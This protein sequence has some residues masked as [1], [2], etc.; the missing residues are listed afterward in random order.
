MLRARNVGTLII[1]G[2]ETD[3]CVASTV[4]SAI[5]IGYKVVIARDAICSS[6]DESQMP[7]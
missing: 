2:S 3:A 4:L 1:S 5:D 6:S 7:F